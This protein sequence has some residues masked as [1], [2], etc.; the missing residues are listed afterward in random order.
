MKTAGY[1]GMWVVHQ[2]VYVNVWEEREREREKERRE[3]YAFCFFYSD[4]DTNQDVSSADDKQRWVG[5]YQCILKERGS[6]AAAL[7]WRCSWETYLFT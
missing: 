6:Q 2:D 5:E 1:S 4:P 3:V 7:G